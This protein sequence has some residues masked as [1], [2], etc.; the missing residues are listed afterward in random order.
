M[1]GL[2]TQH[3]LFLASTSVFFCFFVFLLDCTSA[4]TKTRRRM[5]MGWGG[6]SMRATGTTVTS[7]VIRPSFLLF[8][9]LSAAAVKQKISG[10]PASQQPSI[11]QQGVRFNEYSRRAHAGL[12]GAAPLFVS[13]QQTWHEMCRRWKVELMIPQCRAA[14]A[15]LDGEV[16]QITQVLLP[17]RLTRYNE[18][19][20]NITCR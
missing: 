13:W 8:F 18:Q 1:W 6:G 3:W 2:I 14:A 20:T 11:R 5:E 10:A 19:I 15:A 7:C 12:R 9:F 4:L 16:R 17:S